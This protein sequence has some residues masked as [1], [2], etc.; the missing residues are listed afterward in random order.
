MLLLRNI[1]YNL[2]CL[3]ASAV[4]HDDAIRITLF[5]APPLD[6]ELVLR[7][8]TAVLKEEPNTRDLNP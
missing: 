6:A 1:L 2:Y 8:I 7:A 4:P 5:L 3:N